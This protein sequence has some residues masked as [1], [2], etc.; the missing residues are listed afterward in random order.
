M[1]PLSADGTCGPP[2]IR[3]PLSAEGARDGVDWSAVKPAL[4]ADGT[5]FQA[6]AWGA[7]A[8]F[9]AAAG[10]LLGAPSF[11]SGAGAAFALFTGASLVRGAGEDVILALFIGAS[12]L[13]GG[14]AFSS[15]R[16][17]GAAGVQ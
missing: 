12:R 14:E 11:F 10:A 8:G 5:A 15:G 7:G 6:A 17:A 9:P 16:R 1:L 4:G 3:L 2:G 13:S